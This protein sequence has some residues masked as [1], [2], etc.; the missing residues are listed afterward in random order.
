MPPAPAALER[1]LHLEGL[2]LPYSLRR[3]RRRTVGMQVDERGLRVSAPGGLPL[4]RVEEVIRENAAWIR[5][6]LGEAAERAADRRLSIH[7]GALLPILGEDWQVR[8]EAGA[9]RARWGEGHVILGLREGAEPAPVLTRALQ[10]RA[11]EIFEERLHHYGGHLGQPL[12]P[13]RLSGARTRWGSCSRLSGIRLNWRLIHLPLTLIDYVTAHELA[14]LVEMNHS[15]RFW[16]VVESL[17][18]DWRAARAELKALGPHV[19]LF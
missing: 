8:I 16:A 13:L 7:H 10:R 11:L 17:Y 9:N 15:P 1:S 19:P 3:S 14:H 4:S 5:K 12:P 2:E 18:P 6:K